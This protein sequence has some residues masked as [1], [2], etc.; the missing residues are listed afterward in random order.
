M[1]ELCRLRRS[2][3]YGA[4]L[5]SPGL[6]G[7]AA[8]QTGAQRKRV[9]FGEE[10]QRNDRALPLAAKRGIWSLPKIDRFGRQSRQPNRSPA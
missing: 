6:G 8:N 4:C 3:G 10:E 9:R 2:E 1:I 7:K 5:R